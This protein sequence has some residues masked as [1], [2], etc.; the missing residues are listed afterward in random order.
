MLTCAARVQVLREA[1]AL[2]A[3]SAEP[4]HPNTLRLRACFAAAR[5]GALV[6]ATDAVGGGRTLG[7][8]LAAAAARGAPLGERVARGLFAQAA[9]AVAA[10]HA[11]GTDGGDG[12]CVLAQTPAS[13]VFG[14]FLGGAGY[15]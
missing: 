11:D 4:R 7:D 1:L 10:V 15:G 14:A 12:A 2:A 6:L 9:A 8:A 3:L 13:A 5:G